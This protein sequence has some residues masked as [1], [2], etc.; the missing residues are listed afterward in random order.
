LDADLQNKSVAGVAIKNDG[1]IIHGERMKERCLSYFWHN[2][3]WILSFAVLMV[4]DSLF[5]I[6]LLS[7]F[8]LDANPFSGSKQFD[9]SWH[10][11][12][13]D[14]VLFLV[15]ILSITK[16]KFTSNWLFQGIVVGYGW[17]VVN[18][19]SELLF[20]VDIGIY[21]FLP[22]WAYLLGVLIQFF[23]GLIILWVYRNLRGKKKT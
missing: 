11:G 6:L 23:M 22:G 12:R 3:W 20:G 10:W 18:S 14:S 9:W 1:K 2:K 5:T 15:P 17:S 7:K 13:I 4:L 16:W 8:G 21:Q 19:L